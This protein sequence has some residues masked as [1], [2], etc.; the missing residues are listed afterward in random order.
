MSSNSSSEKSPN[1]FQHQ[2]WKPVKLNCPSTLP[3]CSNDGLRLELGF[4]FGLVIATPTID[5]ASLLK[6]RLDGGFFHSFVKSLTEESE[7]IEVEHARTI[8]V[9]AVEKIRSP[10]ASCI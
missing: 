2:R 6:R 10:D 7:L 8:C 9:E 1:M 4:G 3:A 5:T